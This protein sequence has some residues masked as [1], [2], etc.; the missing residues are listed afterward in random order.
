M[1][2][3]GLTQYKEWQKRK[4]QT[5]RAVPRSLH[6]TWHEVWGAQNRPTVSLSHVEK[7]YI[8]QTSRC[9][10]A[11]LHEHQSSLKGAPYLK[12]CCWPKLGNIV[13]IDKHAKRSTRKT[14][15]AFCIEER[16]N[17]YVSQ[18][19]TVLLDTELAFLGELQ[20][21]L[22]SS[23]SRILHIACDFMQLSALDATCWNLLLVM[24]DLW[25]HRH[26]L[27]VYSMFSYIK[28]SVVGTLS[29][30]LAKSLFQWRFSHHER[31]IFELW[32]RRDEYLSS[33]VQGVPTSHTTSHLSLTIPHTKCR[34]L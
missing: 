22:L 15:V 3:Y 12:E 33:M 29:C 14:T 9:L 8:S 23:L 20:L 11:H 5:R 24:L 1:G 30:A 2:N 19:S 10:Y 16:G 21:C 4:L 31:G 26:T 7:K 6:E 28:F 25:W 18:P 13:I 27:H 32:A 34:N 17:I